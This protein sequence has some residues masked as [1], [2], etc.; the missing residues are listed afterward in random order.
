[1][2]IHEDKLK[3]E[4]ARSDG[5][6]DG[7]TDGESETEKGRAGGEGE[8]ASS[9]LRVRCSARS[10]AMFLRHLRDPLRSAPPDMIYPGHASHEFMF[11]VDSG[12]PIY[13]RMEP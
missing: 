6:T 2:N 5:R 3:M 12:E 8:S 7:R 4:R 9:L 13:G 1:M 10:L 11:H